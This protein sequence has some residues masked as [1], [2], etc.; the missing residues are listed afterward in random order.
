MPPIMEWRLPPSLRRLAMINAGI[1]AFCSMNGFGSDASRR[2]QL[3]LEGLY[4]YC[5]RNILA[6]KEHVEIRVRLFWEETCLR[7][8]VSHHGPGGEWDEQ[9]KMKREIR[10]TSFEAM[11]LVISRD[12]MDD[13][14]FESNY[15]MTAGVM[16]R[17]YAL[18]FALAKPVSEK[19]ATDDN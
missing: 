4:A 13:V 17:T 12:L 1:D 8:E 15:D 11:G 2:V 7:I 9:L 19:D 6:A 3:G 18:Q 14:T 10:R 5:V 16:L